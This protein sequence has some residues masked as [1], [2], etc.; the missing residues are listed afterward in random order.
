MLL[1]S[2]NGE[3]RLLLA[4]EVIDGDDGGVSDAIRLGDADSIGSSGVR[5]NDVSQLDCG[6]DVELLYD[7]WR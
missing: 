6:C 4:W 2:A 7:C 5:S 3:K 1:S